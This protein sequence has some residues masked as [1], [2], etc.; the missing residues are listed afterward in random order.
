[1]LALS[2]APLLLFIHPIQGVFRDLEMFAPAG[3]ALAMLAAYVLGR[4]LGYGPS[5]VFWAIAI[6]FSTMTVV[7]AGL[8][9]RGRWKLTRV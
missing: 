2:F 8:F 6:A 5:G 3:L 7:S 9:R 4:S 1:M